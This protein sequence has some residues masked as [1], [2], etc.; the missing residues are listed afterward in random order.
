MI[1]KPALLNKPRCNAVAAGLVV[2]VASIVSQGNAWGQG[3]KATAA[4]R[5]EIG[6]GAVFSIETRANAYTLDQLID[7]RFDQP[8]LKAKALFAMGD[9]GLNLNLTERGCSLGVE[10]NYRGAA[11]TT[12]E[13]LEAFKGFDTNGFEIA[14]GESVNLQFKSMSWTGSGMTYGCASQVSPQNRFNVVFRWL[15]LDSFH[16][17][18]YSG[19]LSGGSAGTTVSVSEERYAIEPV[20]SLLQTT[21]KG[22]YFGLDAQ[23]SG[24]SLG[25]RFGYRLQ[26]KN[27]VN[28]IRLKNTPFLNRQ[29][30]AIVSDGD[31]I[32][33]D[34][35]PP[36]TG[37]YGNKD[38]RLVAPLMWSLQTQYKL[39]T[40]L[41]LGVDIHGVN[42]TH[43]LLAV[44]Q[45]ACSKFCGPGNKLRLEVDTD[46]TTI[47]F[48][49]QS[50]AFSLGLGFATGSNSTRLKGIN[51]L[52]LRVQI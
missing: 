31:V 23:W 9:G 21:G 52:Q 36:L 46:G 15:V 25:D 3:L 14:P 26:T 34:R 17:K 29:I 11:T 5:S 37:R 42:S 24:E 1:S 16:S 30:D 40:P 41:S 12:R 45:W 33:R 51:Q 2:F 43:Q 8:L 38:A 50:R 7:E 22:Q 44:S 32:Q 28:S 10:Q 35:V 49:Y 4:K 27:L 47:G 6:A 20:F 19:G 39:N 13:T 48:S 18:N